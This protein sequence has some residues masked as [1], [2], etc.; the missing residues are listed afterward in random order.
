MNPAVSLLQVILPLVA[1]SIA[2][3]LLL[4]YYRYSKKRRGPMT[5]PRPG[6]V[7]VGQRWGSCAR[8]PLLG[9]APWIHL[10]RTHRWIRTFLWPPAEPPPYTRTLGHQ[11]LENCGQDFKDV[12]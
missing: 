5:S 11:A 1:V 2:A 12:L 10:R 4:C 6:R 8:G 9:T 7:R 3:V